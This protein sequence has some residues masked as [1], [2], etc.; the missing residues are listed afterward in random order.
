MEEEEL[1]SRERSRYMRVEGVERDEV[2]E[3]KEVE[4]S[5]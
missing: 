4:R 5:E 2:E 1:Q 3:R